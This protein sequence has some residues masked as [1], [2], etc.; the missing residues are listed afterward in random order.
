MVKKMSMFLEENN[1][2]NKDQHGFR[3]GRSCLSQLLA[4]HEIILEML[5]HQK[6]VDVVYLDF[7]KAFDKVDH[8]ILLHKIRQMG[9]T[10]KLGIWLHSF[11]TNREQRVVADGAASQSSVVAS[12]V[13]QGSVLG[14]LLFLIYIYDINKHVKHSSVA[15]FADDT[16]VLKQVSS[17][18]DA[19][20]LQIDLSSLYTWAEHN[21][22]SFNN[23]KFE[24]VHYTLDEAN[25]NTFK[26]K[27]PNGSY[28]DTKDFV[29]DLGITLSNDGNFTQYIYQVAKKSPSQV[30]W[31]LR[32]FRTHEI[33]PKLTLYKSLVIPLLEYCCQLWT[34]RVGE[35]Q[36]LEAIQRSITSRISGVR[37]LD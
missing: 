30:G 37:H 35:K 27:A 23:S 31:I 25:D 32:I 14:P 1:L 9:I 33:T 4:H 8:G 12:G 11:L 24:H 28:I 17:I 16:R 5:E 6:K 10:G 2:M 19:K 21:N 13:P 20:Q 36:S 22:M 3:T 26:Y 18:N 34:W 15:S 29:K 7:A